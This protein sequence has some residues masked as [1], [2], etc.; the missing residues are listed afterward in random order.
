MEKRIIENGEII[1]AVENFK[2]S[3]IWYLGCLFRAISNSD[4]PSGGYISGLACIGER[5]ADIL[6]VSQSENEMVIREIEAVYNK[7]REK[8]EIEAENYKISN[9]KLEELA[10]VHDVLFQSA[11]ERK[12]QYEEA[13]ETKSEIINILNGTIKGLQERLSKYESV[14][15]DNNNLSDKA[16]AQIGNDEERSAK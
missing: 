5:I 13:L 6:E 3:G 8:Y 10:K 15:T 16:D 1:D 14:S 9:H 12:E 4:K 11:E 7:G 2:E